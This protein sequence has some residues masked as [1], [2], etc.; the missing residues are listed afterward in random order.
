[1][2]GTQTAIWHEFWDVLPNKKDVEEG[3]YKPVALLYKY[4][5]SP[6]YLLDFHGTV[7]ER[8]EENKEIAAHESVASIKE[9]LRFSSAYDMNTANAFQGDVQTLCLQVVAVWT[10]ISMISATGS[11]EAK[12][13]KNVSAPVCPTIWAPSLAS[14]M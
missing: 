12:P 9:A 2:A 3:K 7:G 1:M 14:C 13:A 6:P 10:C 8:H 11:L 5:G 4:G